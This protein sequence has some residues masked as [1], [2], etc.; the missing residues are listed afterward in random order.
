MKYL[1]DIFCFSNNLKFIELK[2]Y[3]KI[4]LILFLI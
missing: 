1:F 3:R 2:Y 4:K